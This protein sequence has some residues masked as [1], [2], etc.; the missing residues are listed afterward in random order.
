[1]IFVKKKKNQLGKCQISDRNVTPLSSGTETL[2][3]SDNES[4]SSKIHELICNDEEHL[5]KFSESLLDISVGGN[6]DCCAIGIVISANPE[7]DDLKLKTFLNH[8][9][10]M[11]YP[12]YLISKCHLYCRY[13]VMELLNVLIRS[14]KN[15][16]YNYHS[17]LPC[18]ITIDEQCLGDAISINFKSDLVITPLHTKCAKRP[19][20]KLTDLLDVVLVA[21]LFPNCLYLS[22]CSEPNATEPILIASPKLNASVPSH[23]C[24][25]PLNIDNS[26]SFCF[27]YFI[28]CDI[29]IYIPQFL[30]KCLWIAEY[31][32]YQHDFLQGVFPVLGASHYTCLIFEMS[33]LVFINDINCSGMRSAIL[34]MYIYQFF[35]QTAVIQR[36]VLMISE[37]LHEFSKLLQYYLLIV[38]MQYIF[39]FFKGIK[40]LWISVFN[41][42]TCALSD[43]TISMTTT[44]R[45]ALNCSVKSIGGLKFKIF[46]VHD[47]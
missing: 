35:D 30:Y 47:Y 8:T 20:L 46:S 22:L 9:R 6:G 13:L 15:V 4:I 36:L 40:K 44:A 21:H 38:K 7:S 10:R 24:T 43:S 34:Q 31:L 17:Y 19:R 37:V 2:L 42:V 16:D 28:F 1:M 14:S 33:I 3:F 32:L 41:S 29:K 5:H 26:N 23:P 45:L 25:T 39:E 11:Y 27:L 18:T 12:D